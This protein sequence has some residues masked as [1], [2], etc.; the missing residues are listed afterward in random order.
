MRSISNIL[1]VTT[2]HLIC[3]GKSLSMR[4]L[5]CSNQ[6]ILLLQCWYQLQIYLSWWVLGLYYQGSW[7]LLTPFKCLLNAF[8]FICNII[9]RSVERGRST[10]NAIAS[11]I[12]TYLR[13]LN[14][15][16]IRREPSVWLFWRS[17]RN[18][19]IPVVERLNDLS[20]FVLE[21]VTC[22]QL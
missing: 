19:E 5:T 11:N 4:T 14:D 13:I 7:S 15:V 6:A 1:W 12:S 9:L 16:G 22:L 3:G 8:N 20:L 18:W 10:L 2:V 17:L 21:E